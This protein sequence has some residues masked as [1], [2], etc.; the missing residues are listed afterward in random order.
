M[1]YHYQ[2]HIYRGD[3]KIKIEIEI[4]DNYE[5]FFNYLKQ[6][7]NLEKKTYIEDIIK[8]EI[9]SRKKDFKSN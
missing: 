1:K 6:N 2:Y 8:D 5:E 7:F 9:E 3:K 4:P